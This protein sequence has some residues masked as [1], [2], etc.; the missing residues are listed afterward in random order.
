ML[1]YTKKQILRQLRAHGW[2]RTL[3]GVWW[4]RSHPI[5][6]KGVTLREA[7]SFEALMSSEDLTES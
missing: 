1:S 3:S 7:A 4:K 6:K 2:R 5:G